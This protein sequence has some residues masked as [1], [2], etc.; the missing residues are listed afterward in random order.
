MLEEPKTPKMDGNTMTADEPAVEEDTAQ[1]NCA[2]TEEEWLGS[3]F[4]DS[5]FLDKE[6][7]YTKES[8][9]L[10]VGPEEIAKLQQTGETSRRHEGRKQKGA[11]LREEGLIV[12]NFRT[13]DIGEGG[14]VGPPKAVSSS[15]IKTSTR[16]SFARTPRETEDSPENSCKVLLAND[17]QRRSQ[18]VLFLSIMPEVFTQKGRSSTSCYKYHYYLEMVLITNTQSSQ[19]THNTVHPNL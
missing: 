16:N 10:N 2:N 12:E 14:T 19:L 1:S 11:I 9:N 8:P 18:L 13:L 4:D 7:V 6:P 5:I 3:S 17:I 15:C